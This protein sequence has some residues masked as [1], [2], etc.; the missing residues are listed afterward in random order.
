[1]S[2]GERKQIECT[3][4]GGMGI[5]E[6]CTCCR[7]RSRNDNIREHKPLEIPKTGSPGVNGL[8]FT[9][10]LSPS[11]EDILSGEVTEKDCPRSECAVCEFYD[12][13]NLPEKSNY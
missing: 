9:G 4:K 7:C 11:A 2:S 3:S 8:R 10:E 12:V 5:E 13:C 6:R 1:M